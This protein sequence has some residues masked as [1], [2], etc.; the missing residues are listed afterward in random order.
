MIPVVRLGL[1]VAGVMASAAAVGL[2]LSAGTPVDPVPREAAAA[3]PEA[4]LRARIASDFGLAG[5]TAGFETADYAAA[6]LDRLLRTRVDPALLNGAVSKRGQDLHFTPADGVRRH[7]G[8]IVI[9]YPD[10]RAAADRARPLL[11]EKRFFTATK[12]L[13]PMT[14]AVRGDMLVIFFTESGGD[15]K[16]RATLSHA[17][18]AFQAER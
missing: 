3:D 15:A 18:G 8:V 4:L 17:A 13:T 9:R 10:A 11:G 7:A 5:N 16:L 6:D 12:I 2:S 1:I 14:A